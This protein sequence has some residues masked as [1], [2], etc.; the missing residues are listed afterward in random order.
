MGL[1]QSCGSGLY[2]HASGNLAHRFEQGQTAQP[3]Y[4]F[5]GNADRFGHDKVGGLLRIRSKVQ[6]SEQN[7]T[8]AQHRSFGGLRLLDLYDHIAFFKDF[9]RR[10]NNGRSRNY[11]FAVF[12]ANAHA[13]AGFD[14]HIMT[15]GSKFTRRFGG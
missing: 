5:I 9:G 12:G 11:I 8:F 3:G 10:R 1:F 2:R 6:I 13:C 4:G 14:Q 7:L 15:V